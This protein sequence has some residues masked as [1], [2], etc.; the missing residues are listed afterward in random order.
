MKK[1]GYILIILTVMLSIF[2]CG[3][4][5]GRNMNRSSI[6]ITEYTTVSLE[7]EDTAGTSGKVNINTA[8]VDE[9]ILLPGIGQTLAQRIVDYRSLIGPFRTVSDLSNVEG[10]GDQK[11]LSL[12]EYITI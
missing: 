1:A 10:I 11:L 4:L 3:F 7:L 8:S 9:L 5:V 6:T 12:L 2:I